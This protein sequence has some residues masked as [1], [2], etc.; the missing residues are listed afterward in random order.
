[1]YSMYRKKLFIFICLITILLMGCNK[2]DDPGDLTQGGTTQDVP[3]N[4][5]IQ[6][7]KLKMFNVDFQDDVYFLMGMDY[8][9]FQKI[10]EDE[11]IEIY[12]EDSEERMSEHYYQFKNGIGVNINNNQVTSVGTFYYDDSIEFPVPTLL[13]INGDDDYESVI[14][15]LGTPFNDDKESTPPSLVYFVRY[16][17]YV[18]IFFDSE[19]G[20]VSYMGC[21]QQ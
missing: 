18:K 17:T 8:T 15:K 13:G 1:M 5:S 14:S 9:L 11:V 7:D 4:G 2:N 6:N 10:I 19:T 12:E 3:N 20:K 16:M 21:F